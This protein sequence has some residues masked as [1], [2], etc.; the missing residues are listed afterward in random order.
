MELPTQCAA[1]TC[2]KPMIFNSVIGLLP[3]GASFYRPCGL[4]LLSKLTLRTCLFWVPSGL[5]SPS[6]GRLHCSGLICILS[7][8]PIGMVLGM[9]FCDSPLTRVQ[10]AIACRLRCCGLQ[11]LLLNLPHTPIVLV[12]QHWVPGL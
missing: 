7:G 3:L 11:G 2:K 9:A 12:L 6:A 8:V 1:R 5:P 10:G 4:S